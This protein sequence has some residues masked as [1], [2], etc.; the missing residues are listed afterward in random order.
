MKLIT[1][2]KLIPLSPVLMLASLLAVGCGSSNPIRAEAPGGNKGLSH[3]VHSSGTY[4]LYHV[5]QW[6]GQ[7]QPVNA[8]IVASYRLQRNQRVG[9]KYVFGSNAQWEPDAQSSVIAF[10]G[11][12][13]LDLGPIHSPYEKYY[14]ADPSGW[15]AY[16]STAPARDAIKAISMD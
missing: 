12:H 8:K 5:T 3:R 15:G 16:W 4:S 11:D 1:R 6:N 13:S 7:G 2:M 14:W 10:A 9:F